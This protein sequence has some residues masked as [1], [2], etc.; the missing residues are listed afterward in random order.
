MIDTGERHVPKYIELLKQALGSSTL[1]C[2][3]IT[4]WH[5]DH[6][7]GIDDVLQLVGPCPIYKVRRGEDGSIGYKYTYVDDGFEIKVSDFN[8]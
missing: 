2:I 4:H 1:E 7:G 5:E 6:V 8:Y 3:L